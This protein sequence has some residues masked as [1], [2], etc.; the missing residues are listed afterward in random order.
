V[1]GTEEAVFADMATNIGSFFNSTG[2]SIGFA[3]AA[4]VVVDGDPTEQ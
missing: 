1:G 2:T 3:G 4:P